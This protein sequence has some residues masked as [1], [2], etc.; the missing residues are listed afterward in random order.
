MGLILLI[1]PFGILTK[2]GLLYM[3]E[4]IRAMNIALTQLAKRE[5]EL[6]HHYGTFCGLSDPAVWVLYTLYED[7][8]NIYTQNDLVSMWSFPKQTLNNT[9]SNLVKKGWVQ[10]EQLPG[11]RNS[12]AIKLTKEG[13]QVCYEKILPLMLA[14]ERSL[15][16]LTDD[17]Q[18]TLL[19]LFE[20]QCTYFEEEIKKITGK[21][22]GK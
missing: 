12:K 21:K 16:R 9:V 10:L 14:E 15:T 6:Y 17:E 20:K 11:A 19:R 13:Q 18:R 22:E 2:R 7:E 8:K 4:K 1:I 5:E 3:T